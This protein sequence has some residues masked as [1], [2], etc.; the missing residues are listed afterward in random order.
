MAR[1]EQGV[2]DFV[3][4]TAAAMAAAGFPRM[5]ARVLIALVAA[6]TSGL[7]AKELGEQLG[8]SPAAI[9]GAVRYLRVLRMVHRVSQPGS[10][11]D[12]YELPEHAWYTASV[13][14]N[15]FYDQMEVLSARAV[16]AIDDPDSLAS[17]R[18]EEMRDFFVFMQGRLPGLLEEWQASREN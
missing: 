3:E 8:A 2:T 4:Q 10:R 18:I 11:R 7:T 17:R 6:E 1:D 15:P 12:R 5:S 13:S 14:K 16:A 9:S